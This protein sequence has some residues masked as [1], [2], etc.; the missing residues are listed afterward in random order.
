MLAFLGHLDY[1]CTPQIDL[2]IY[3]CILQNTANLLGSV[4]ARALYRDVVI[5]GFPNVQTGEKNDKGVQYI[6]TQGLDAQRCSI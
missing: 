3:I 1:N 5:I 2:D 6:Y 4:Y